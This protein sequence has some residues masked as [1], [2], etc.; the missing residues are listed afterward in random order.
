MIQMGN[1]RYDYEISQ[2]R[3]TFFV[4]IHLLRK[5]SNNVIEQVIDN[6]WHPS[7]SNAHSAHNTQNQLRLRANIFP[8]GKFRME[9]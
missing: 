1:G 2:A 9:K 3:L 5:K 7:F 6:Y 8:F 4:S